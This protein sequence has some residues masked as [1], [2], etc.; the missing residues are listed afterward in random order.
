MEA[1]WRDV[2]GKPGKRFSCPEGRTPLASRGGFP[3]EVDQEHDFANAV[4]DEAAKTLA[5]E[6]RASH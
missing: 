2:S 4:T 3:A 1:S 6:F 5:D